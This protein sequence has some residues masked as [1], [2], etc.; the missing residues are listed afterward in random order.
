MVYS[1]D[2]PNLDLVTNG[3]TQAEVSLS[4]EGGRPECTVS[5]DK[6]HGGGFTTPHKELAVEFLVQ[7]PLPRSTCGTDT[8]EP[9]RGEEPPRTSRYV[10]SDVTEEQFLAK[11]IIWISHEFRISCSPQTLLS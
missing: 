11:P 4:A 10:L 8:G 6:I 2:S 9:V 5:I 3:P 7:H 1:L